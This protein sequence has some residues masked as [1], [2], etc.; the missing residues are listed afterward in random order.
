MVEKNLAP[1]LERSWLEVELRP[2]SPSFVTAK[3][4]ED[5]QKK[6]AKICNMHIFC[7][8]MVISPDTDDS[9]LP[10]YSNKKFKPRDWNGYAWWTRKDASNVMSILDHSHESFYYYPEHDLIDV[11]I[12][13]CNAYD[14]QKVLKFIYKFWKPDSQGIRYAFLHPNNKKTEWKIYIVDKVK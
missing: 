8:P 7:G 3:K 6:L 1:N 14:L 11:S 13:T 9:L 5:F 12:A 4:V 10:Y 2:S